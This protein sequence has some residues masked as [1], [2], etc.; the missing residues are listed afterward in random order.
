MNRFSRKKGTAPDSYAVHQHDEVAKA[1]KASPATVEKVSA[2]VSEALQRDLTP[3]EILYVRAAVVG[4]PWSRIRDELRGEITEGNEDAEEKARQEEKEGLPADEEN[5]LRNRQR[6]LAVEMIKKQITLQVEEMK[7]GGKVVRSIDYSSLVGEDQHPTFYLRGDLW[8]SEA[9]DED[10]SRFFFSKSEPANQ[11]DYM[12]SHAWFD[13]GD[14]KM[15]GG[16]AEKHGLRALEKEWGRVKAVG[17]KNVMRTIKELEGMQESQ[18]RELRFFLDKAAI[19]QFSPE[20]KAVCVKSLEEVLLKSKGC[21]VLLNPRYLRRIWCSFEWSVFLCSHHP[22]DVFVNIRSFFWAANRDT[23]LNHI[24]DYAVETA[25]CKVEFDRTIL[26]RKVQEFY[27]SN[28]HFAIYFKT[29]LIALIVRDFL[30]YVH[31]IKDKG[32]FDELVQPFIDLAKEFAF[33]ELHDSLSSFVVVDE[34]EAAKNDE[35]KYQTRLK[36]HFNAKVYPLLD[37]AR[38]EACTEAGLALHRGATV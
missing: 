33:D 34:L 36:K 6:D 7:N 3:D 24:R 37:L 21:I 31:L 15:M 18:L 14:S 11:I 25:E 32:Q 10:V 5:T 27:K 28:K 29:T 8:A 22:S 20:A 1:S 2:L 35:A 23:Y 26:Q 17:F 30:S 19:P 13:N 4:M 12:I 9:E 16:I 38:Q